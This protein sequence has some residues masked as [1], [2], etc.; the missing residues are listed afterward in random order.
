[1]KLIKIGTGIAA[2]SLIASAFAPAIFATDS[3]GGGT[4]IDVS[5]NGAFSSN[6][7][8]I[9]NTCVTGVT[10]SNTSLVGVNTNVSS[11]TGGNSV[12]GTTGGDVTVTS[13]DATSSANI[14]VGGST[15]TISSSG[16][17][18]CCVCLT[19]LDV[20]IDNN[21]ALSKNKVKSTTTTVQTVGQ[22]NVSQVGVNTNLSSKTGK[23]KV[24]NTTGG[25]VG[26]TSGNSSSSV[27]VTVTAPSNSL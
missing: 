23:N 13:G 5:G 12:S 19:G 18:S 26:V 27:G 25:S 6:S 4:T 17:P 2:A 8:T 11:N 7:V 22:A 9:S 15:N 14:T 21:G 20:T 10:Q 3:L 16:L 1:M 24:K